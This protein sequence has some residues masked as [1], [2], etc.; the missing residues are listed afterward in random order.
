MSDPRLVQPQR[1]PIPTGT[2]DDA[3]AHRYWC[4]TRITVV[5][6]LALVVIAGVIGLWWWIG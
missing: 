4:R 1:L 6:L 5:A 3:C 2:D